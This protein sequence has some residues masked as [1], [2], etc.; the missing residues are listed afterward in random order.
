V[1]SEAKVG[2]A[3]IG[4]D[5]R[6]D[7]IAAKNPAA[8]PRRDEIFAIGVDPGRNRRMNGDAEVVKS[9]S[10]AGGLVDTGGNHRTGAVHERSY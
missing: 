7:A 3:K 6:I 10:S 8:P 1:L 5:F 4:S 2:A 9:K